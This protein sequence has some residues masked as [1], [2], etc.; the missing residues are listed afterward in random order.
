MNEIMKEL[1]TILPDAGPQPIG[2]KCTSAYLHTHCKMLKPQTEQKSTLVSL[3]LI[4]I[5]TSDIQIN[6]WVIIDRLDKPMIDHEQFTNSQ[7]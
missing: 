7:H 3:S 1:D 2:W 5:A 6:H 4:D